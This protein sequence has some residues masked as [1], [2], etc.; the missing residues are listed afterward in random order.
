MFFSVG[1]IKTSSYNSNYPYFCIRKIGRN[2]NWS[3]TMQENSWIK[4]ES[5]KI[6]IDQ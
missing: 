3:K 2:E 6:E 1:V 4:I 5:K